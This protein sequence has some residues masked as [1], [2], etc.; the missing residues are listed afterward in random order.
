[1]GTFDIVEFSAMQDRYYNTERGDHCWISNVSQVSKQ[2][3]S[4]TSV[5]W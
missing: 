2:K 3:I 4:G 1:M 5:L